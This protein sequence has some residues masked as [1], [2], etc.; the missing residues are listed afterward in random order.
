MSVADGSI[1]VRIRLADAMCDENRRHQEDGSLFL[2]D[3]KTGIG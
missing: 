2:I 3:S 1:H